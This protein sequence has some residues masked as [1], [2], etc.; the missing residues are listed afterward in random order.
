MAGTAKNYAPAKIQQ[1]PGDLWL[2]GGGAPADSATPQLTLAADGTPDAGAHP[3]SIHLGLAASG[4][5]SGVKPKVTPIT[6]DNV[7]AAVAAYVAE[8][9]MTLEVELLQYDMA[10][11]QYACPGSGTYATAGGYKQI[12]FGGSTTVLPLSCFALISP[13]RADPTKFI[14]S[15]LFQAYSPGPLQEVISR[16]KHTTWKLTLDAITDLTRTA[17]RQLGVL[18]ETL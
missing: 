15:M 11:M 3:A 8:L 5:T 14:V 6:A 16:G 7:D 18:Y 2:I 17:G 12:T 10:L 9:A 4:I 13:K 1:G